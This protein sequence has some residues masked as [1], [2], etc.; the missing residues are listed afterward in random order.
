[1]EEE[2]RYSLGCKNTTTGFR[3]DWHDKAKPDKAGTAPMIGLRR[4]GS[5]ASAGT[6]GESV[7]RPQ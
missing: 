7:A 4:Y 1:M 5:L 2:E 3:H 6:A